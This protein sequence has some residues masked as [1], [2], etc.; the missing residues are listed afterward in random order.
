[1]TLED[2][3]EALRTYETS[4]WSHPIEPVV[5]AWN[6]RGHVQL[7]LPSQ[8][9]KATA[10]CHVRLEDG[11]TRSW[12]VSQSGHRGGKLVDGALYVH[13]R[14]VLPFR[15]PHGYHRLTVEIGGR[16][17]TALVISA[18]ARAFDDRSTSWGG[19]LP[20]HALHSSRSWG[21][22]DLSDLEALARWLSSE[23]G[24]VV[25][26]L[27]L[28]ASFLGEVP[29][30]PS[31][32]LPVSR[33]FWNEIYVDPRE[34]PEFADS[35]AAR[36]LVGSSVFEQEV[37][38]LQSASFV[39]YRRVMCLKREVLELLAQ[40]L[41]RRRG[42]RRA[43]LQQ[44]TQ[45]HPLAVKYATFRATSERLR[46][47]FSMWPSRLTP[48][49]L[50]E[51]RT[52]RAAVR[53][54]LYAQWVADAQIARVEH[55]A[56]ADGRSLYLDFPLGVHPEGFDVWQ[57]PSLFAREV[58]LGAPP[59]ELFADGQNW[60]A[61]PPQPG[62][63]RADGY[64]YFRAALTRQLEKSDTLRIDHVMGF[65]RLYWIPQGFES[66]D[67]LYVHYP[68]DE[69]YAILCLESHLHHTRI[70]G[71][72]LG[73]VPRYVN[74]T[75]NQHGVGKLHVA[76][77]QVNRRATRPLRPVPAHALA[78]VNTHDT[79]TFQGFLDGAD[80]TER[81]SRGVVEPDGA[82]RERR[83]R[84]AVVAALRR[85][86]GGASPGSGRSS[87]LSLL[88]RCLAQLA[89][90]RASLV[91]VNLEDLWLEVSPQNVPGTS[92][93]RPNW[94]RKAR[95]GLE[96]F[97]TLRQVVETLRRVARDRSTRGPR[98]RR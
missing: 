96:T 10:R 15:L 12:T 25:S 65:H 42:R 75:M 78:C 63:M 8:K 4:L 80:I 94:Q 66:T 95:H 3:V 37:A 31:P 88:Q 53:Y 77:F 57:H 56:R 38:S 44:W 5:V 16:A 76:Q 67:G 17:H 7:R 33:L 73:T 69:L 51:T 72:N 40:S 98:P 90:S 43:E 27:P 86:P 22:G 26:T 6:G 97:T 89:R 47:P 92:W 48:Q 59:D 64:R 21:I 85:I 58:A 23:G 28:L 34:I 82:R 61:P 32:Y 62:A 9:A 74:R 41:G 68:A 2:A 83:R 54:H 18:P 87:S 14:H 79:P 13:R 70:I 49:T 20:L 36:R 84:Q 55:Q 81:L 39:D 19:F 11:S 50:R 29:F 46:Q 35:G 1:M 45:R 60:M 91:I 30:E 52:D 71:E 93:E 24:H